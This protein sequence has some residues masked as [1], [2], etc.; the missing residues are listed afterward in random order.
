M[1]CFLL[2][3]FLC[4]R[5]TVCYISLLVL[6]FVFFYGL[7]Q[8]F[9]CEEKEHTTVSRESKCKALNINYY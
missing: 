3:M 5:V 8:D 9:S 4:L 2:K 6:P 1:E 7:G